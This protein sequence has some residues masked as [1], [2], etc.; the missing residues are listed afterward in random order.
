VR[1]WWRE[2]IEGWN[3][4][5]FTPA[6][7][8]TLSLIRVLA[9][10]MLLYTHAV[11]TLE[12][13][14][15]FADDGWISPAAAAARQQGTY[16]WSHFYYI[17]SATMLWTVHI[18]ALVVFAMLAVGLASR[19][20]SVL[21]W[22]LAVS[23]VH[24]LPGALFGLDQVNTMLAMYLMVGPCGARYSLDRLIQRLR[25]KEPVDAAHKP[26]VDASVAANVAMRLLQLHMCIVYL[27]AGTSKLLGVSWW[28][29]QAMWGAVANLEYQ[30]L[31]MT[32]MADW[33]LLV[34]T[35]THLT[36]YWEIFYC[37]LV[38]PRHTRPVVLLLA[39]PLHLGIAACMGMI[40]F[41]LAM[42]I[43]NLAF[44]PPRL[45]RALVDRSPRPRR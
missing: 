33:P 22:L 40:T 36:V 41:G 32:W 43:A 30:S 2:A 14:D 15:F 5:W 25:G 9:G 1:D 8:A 45:V 23:Y 35:L 21:A 17:H 7:P 12:L 11:W 31:D 37:A 20:V 29:G 18:A 42:L 38:W 6:D 16:V 26:A 34:C 13:D 10:L 27:F 44:V 39:V 19:V 28:T 24:R 4:F 3:R